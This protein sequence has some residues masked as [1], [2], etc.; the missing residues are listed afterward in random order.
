MTERLGGTGRGGDAARH[1]APWC[2]NPTGAPC[3]CGQSLARNLLLAV[4]G[5]IDWVF[6]F[7]ERH[8]CLG[9]KLA[10]TIVRST[11]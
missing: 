10:G 2:A 9:D 11:K 8:Q 5:P 4:L 7:G 3:S 1:S 6:I